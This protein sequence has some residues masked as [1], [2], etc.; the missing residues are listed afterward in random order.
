M[1]TTS[2]KIKELLFGNC[3]DLVGG[4]PIRAEITY[5][6]MD[7]YRNHIYWDGNKGLIVSLF[8]RIEKIEKDLESIKYKKNER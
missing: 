4:T 6:N 1:K 8:E 7:G 3:D 5:P 2:R